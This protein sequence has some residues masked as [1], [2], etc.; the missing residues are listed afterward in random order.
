MKGVSLRGSLTGADLRLLRI[1]ASVAENGG[2]AAA[3][4][5]LNINRSTISVHIADL[6]A[7]LGMRLCNRSRGRSAFSL[8]EQGR[9]LYQCVKD[10]EVSLEA[11]RYQ[12]NAIQSDI[13]GQ[14]RLALPDD[15]L[16][17][18]TTGIDIAPVIARFC[19]QAPRVDLNI[20]AR[21]PQEIDFDILNG[22]AEIGINTVLITR[23]GLEYIP[24]FQHTN[25]LYCGKSHPLYDRADCN[26]NITIEEVVSYELATT[27]SKVH[28][29]AERLISLFRHRAKAGHMAG[30]LLLINSGKFIGFLPDYYVAAKASTHQLRRIM[31]DRLYY[32]LENALIYKTGADK[33]RLVKLFV[34][35]V[36][37]EL[38]K[39]VLR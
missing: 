24:V 22:N 4:I 23:P 7:R 18:S 14:L 3:E 2:F 1:F 9:A 8:T 25:Y 11:F 13:T 32:G 28:F 6:E 20:V 30:R 37:A 27:E 10:M 12:I 34:D 15:L 21:A 39:Q 35:L 5:A 38:H 17:M 31:P 16:E 33:S 29:E 26:S 36:K 19:E